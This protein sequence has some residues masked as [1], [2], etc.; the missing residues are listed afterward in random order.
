VREFV[1][2]AARWIRVDPVAAPT[3]AQ[4]KAL[5]VF[6]PQH[7]LLGIRRLLTA[8]RARI[9]PVVL[10]DVDNFAALA[11]RGTDLTW[12]ADVADENDLDG[13]GLAPLC[14]PSARP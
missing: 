10:E 11:L 8:G 12:R 7:N 2:Q 13:M 3:A 6:Y 14:L 4:L 1:A 5:Q 9:G